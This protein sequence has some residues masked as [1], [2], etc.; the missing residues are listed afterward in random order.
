MLREKDY[1]KGQAVEILR[2]NMESALVERFIELDHDIWTVELAKVDGFISK[3][4]WVN[5]E[6]PGEV[7]TI[8]YWNSL[9]QWK[10]IDH[11][12]LV[13]VD[14]KFTTLMGGDGSFKMEALHVGNDY[15]RVRETIKF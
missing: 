6:K 3:D 11:D 5:K 8:I 4:I 1:G 14:R 7:T 10:A 13:E 9:D 12:L 15:Y 2:F